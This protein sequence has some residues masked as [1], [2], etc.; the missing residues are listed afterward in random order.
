VTTV[1]ILGSGMMGTALAFPLSDNGHD[2][3]LVGT[4]LDRDI[5][6]SIKETGVHPGLDRK[7]P[8][9]VRAYQLEEAEE[10]FDGAEVAMSGVNSFG[11]RWAGKQFA[12]LLKP[13]M[14]VLSIAKGM[15]ASENGDLRILPEV[16][17]EEVPPELRDQVS[18]SAIAG[19][20]IAGEVAAR[21]DT[22][23]VFTCRD[24]SVAEALASLFR[25]S[26]YH[27]WTSDDFVGVEVCAAAKNCY[28]LAAGFADGILERLGEV[29]SADQN[30]NYTAALFG[31]GAVELGQ[32]MRLLGGRPETPYGLAGVGDMYVTSAGGRNV[33]VG[34]L[35]GSG[36]RF[37]EARA[38]MPGITLEGAAA[39]AVIG[40]AMAKLT[41]RGVMAPEDFPLMRHLHA[42]IAEDE[43]L[44]MPWSAFFG[45]E[46]QQE[47]VEE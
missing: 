12:S 42:V 26:Y 3:R 18:W 31:Q 38:S 23:V 32:L 19:P 2:V 28:A 24:A 30:Y 13:G 22:C 20:S 40:G 39:I 4:F 11:V 33:R 21:R 37:S 17:A 34:R 5:I 29:E 25:T 1:S 43:P 44:D 14:H 6:D 10:A 9:S 36:M 45:G 7:V 47:W 16:L 15:E 8:E 41:G 27:V 46:P 35:I